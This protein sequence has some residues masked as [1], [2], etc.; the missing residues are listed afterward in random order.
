M[1]GAWSN[2][3]RRVEGPVLNRRIEIT[4]LRRDGAEFPVELTITPL[5]TGD[6]WT[7][8]AFIRDIHRAAEKLRKRIYCATRRLNSRT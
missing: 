7:F 5:K 1:N 6:T 3:S 8:S 2:F 4:A